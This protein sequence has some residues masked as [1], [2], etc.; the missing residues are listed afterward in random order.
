MP[1]RSI[2]TQRTTGVEDEPA[3]QDEITESESKFGYRSMWV[4]LQ[5]QDVIACRENMGQL[6]LRLYVEGAE[7]RKSRKLWRIIYQTL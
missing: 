2:F 4:S 6:L 5:K 7:R 3:V 1:E